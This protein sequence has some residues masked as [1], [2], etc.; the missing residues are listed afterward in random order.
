MYPFVSARACAVRAG[1]CA[2]EGQA[3]QSEGGATPWH[4][5][6][7]DEALAKVDSTAEGL[8]KPEAA[9]RVERYGQNVVTPGKSRTLLQMIW[10]QLYN[11][12]TAI[13]LVAG[14][15]SGIRREWVEMGFILAVVVVNVVIGVVQEGKAE[16]ATQAIKRMVSASSVVLRNGRKVTLE[17]TGLVPGDVVYLAPGDRIPADV[18]WL[19]ASELRVTEAALTGESTAVAKTA[20]AVDAAAVLADRTCMGY[21]GTLVFTGQGTGLVVA[22]GDDAEIGRIN[23]MMANVEAVKTPLLAQIESFGFNLSVL[24]IVVALLT[25]V[26]GLLLRD[27]G[28]EGALEAGVS[29]AVA[30]I[31]EGLPTVVT[32]TL[33]LGVQAMAASNAIIRQLPAVETLGA[34][35]CICSDKT[36]TLTKN[37]MTAVA[38][39]TTGGVVRA[40]GSGYTPEGRMTWH[41]EPLGKDHAERLKQLLLPAA[42]CNDATLM[43]VVSSHARRIMSMES[44]ALPQLRGEGSGPEVEP[45]LRPD[46]ELPL[47]DHI[48]AAG[49]EVGAAISRAMSTL[50]DMVKWETTGDPTEAALLALAMKAG[51]NLRTLF[52]LT[53]RTPRLATLPFSSDTKFMATLHDIS[54]PGADADAGDGDGDGAG[55]QPPPRRVLLVK[56][57]PDVLLARCGSQAKDGDPWASEPLEL[58]RWTSVNAELSKEGMRVLALCSKDMGPGDKDGDG[59]GDGAVTLRR[60]AVL[61]GEPD[62]RLHC[63]VAIVDP[64]R[65]EAIRSVESCHRAGITVKMVT[66]DHADTAATIG[67]WIGIDT[68]E[69]LTGAVLEEMSDAELQARVEGCNIFARTSPEHKLRIVR[70]LQQHKHVVAMTGDGVNDAPALRQ[71]SVGVAMGVEG[72]EVAKEAS[73]MIL[74]DD[75]F[76]TIEG[77]VRQGRRTFDNLRKLFLFILPTTIAQGVSVAAAVFIGVPVPLTPVQILYVNMITAATLGLVLAAEEAEPG[78]M[79]RPPRAPTKPLVGKHIKWRSIFVGALMITAMLTQQAWTRGEG[80]DDRVVHTMAMNTLV[81]AQCF[82]CVSCRFLR[83]SSVGLHALTGNAWLTAMVILNVALQCLITYT[84]G[85]QDVWDTASIGIVDWLRI[86]AFAILIFSIVEAEKVLGPQFVHPYI[87]PLMA[88]LGCRTRARDRAPGTVRVRTGS[89]SMSVS[90]HENTASGAEPTGAADAQV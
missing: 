67:R 87:L 40:S 3:G 80:R 44:L 69:V 19:S 62:L 36:G 39:H 68:D 11:I 2:G 28:L 85:V 5:L 35:T 64:P 54:P 20:E 60:D 48:E 37:E 32:I 16:A 49:E 86:L 90:G 72:T 50:L 41:D 82:Y 33:A 61:G 4:A 6:T 70:A 9:A 84:P 8:S 83:R 78:I 47:P 43:P 63:L 13:L 26:V 74:Q 7:P 24:C 53:Q 71:A 29:V 46:P 10:E 55:D 52:A 31:P 57:A 51:L 18:R 81:I 1:T 77:A 21:S 66:G 59:D 25:F 79:D 75:N 88:R 12:I 76:A 27:L 58:E 45:Q 22:T 23:S 38:I 73:R 15:I 42:L 30:L 14:I 34:L 17:A 56:G 89:R 65:E